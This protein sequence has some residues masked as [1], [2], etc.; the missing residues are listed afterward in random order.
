VSSPCL[1]SIV[2]SK[3]TSAAPSF[4]LRLFFLQID[5]DDDDDDVMSGNYGVGKIV[6]LRIV[7]V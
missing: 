6:Q 5:D 3:L 2:P 7:A 4:V 1:S